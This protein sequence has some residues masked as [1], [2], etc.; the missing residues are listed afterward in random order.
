MT[1]QAGDGGEESARDRR[2]CGHDSK[3]SGGACLSQAPEFLG[4]HTAARAEARWEAGWER[5]SFWVLLLPEE[6]ALKS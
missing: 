6:A 1:P 3:A 4:C 5:S 2:L